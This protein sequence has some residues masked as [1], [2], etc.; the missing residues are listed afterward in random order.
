[1]ADLY[2]YDSEFDAST[3]QTIAQQGYGIADKPIPTRDWKSLAETIMKQTKVGQLVLSFH[4]FDGGMVVGGNA[5]TLSEESVTKLFTKRPTINK[6]AFAGC[7]VGNRPAEMA[8][9]ARMFG[10]KSVSGYT[11]STVKQT[12]KIK[13]P[14]G[15]TEEAAKKV[16]DPLEQYVVGVLPAAKVVA[17]QTHKSRK[18]YEVNLVILYG[19]D[20]GSTASAIPIP[21]RESKNRKPWKKAAK[22]EIPATQAKKAEQAYQSSPVVAFELVTVLF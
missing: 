14:K 16:L 15:T 18:D 17:T 2:L 3:E 20:D 7:N 4:S 13:L 12:L 6:I 5:R 1:M 9:F 22:T 10:A 8:A 11:W 21:E 19:S